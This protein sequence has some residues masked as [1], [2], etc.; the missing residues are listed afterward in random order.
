MQ[1]FSLGSLNYLPY[2]TNGVSAL[3]KSESRIQS[4][5]KSN[6]YILNF[7]MKIWLSIYFLIHFYDYDFI[8]FYNKLRKKQFI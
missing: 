7:L 4:L 6:K 3:K 8:L 1:V 5:I 2:P